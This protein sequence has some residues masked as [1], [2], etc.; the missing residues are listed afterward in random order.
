MKRIKKLN[1]VR[2]GCC[3]F[4]L[5]SEGMIYTGPCMSLSKDEGPRPWQWHVGNVE[6]QFSDEDLT[7]FDLYD[8]YE[9][10][11]AKQEKAFVD[12][13]CETLY[14]HPLAWQIRV[15]NIR[16]QLKAR[17][18]SDMKTYRIYE[19]WLRRNEPLSK[20]MCNGELFDKKEN[21]Q[22][23]L[24]VCG[25]GKVLV[26]YEAIDHSSNVD[27]V[28][29]EMKVEIYPKFFQLDPLSQ[30]DRLDMLIEHFKENSDA[31]VQIVNAE[32]NQSGSWLSKKQKNKALQILQ[33][34]MVFLRRKNTVYKIV[35]SLGKEKEASKDVLVD[36]VNEVQKFMG[37]QLKLLE[38]GVGKRVSDWVS[39]IQLQNINP[40]PE[41][42]IQDELGGGVLSGD[43]MVCQKDKDGALGG[44]CGCSDSIVSDLEFL[45]P[46]QIKK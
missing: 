28:M 12:A 40:I 36:Y 42:S 5:L 43:A 22:K 46:K 10:L 21:L 11:F 31:Y 30:H 45:S 38:H 17:M 41:Q 6:T 27:V 34:Y 14:I 3:L 32:L 8:L 29:D 39:G 7:D 19:K 18:F 20:E 13:W 4:F 16:E 25:C 37:R 1:H 26:S 33:D 24:Q 44:Q 2:W 15:I 23:F 35:D 9:E